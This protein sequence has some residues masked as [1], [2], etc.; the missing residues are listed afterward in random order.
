M[1]DVPEKHAFAKMIKQESLCSNSS[2]ESYIDDAFR[3]SD[4]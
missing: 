1:K 3:L 2:V 4:K